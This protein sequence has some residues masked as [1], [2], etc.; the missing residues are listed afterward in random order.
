MAVTHHA[1]NMVKIPGSAGT[2]TI[3][4]HVL[5]ATRAVETAYK[6]A[7]MAFPVDEDQEP[8]ESPKKKKQLFSQEAAATKK[9]SLSSSSSGAEGSGA[10]FTIG[11]ALPPK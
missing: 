3:R 8:L 7:A 5:D 4:G 1:Y 6:T 9:I 2:I 10:S 11:A